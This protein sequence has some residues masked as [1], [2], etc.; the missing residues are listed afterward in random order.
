[1]IRA[2]PAPGIVLPGVRRVVLG[3]Q[4]LRHR[5]T[6]LDDGRRGT[7]ER[8][9]MRRCRKAGYGVH[10]LPPGIWR[11]LARV[12]V[13]QRQHRN[14]PLDELLGR[15]RAEGLVRPRRGLALILFSSVPERRLNEL[16]ERHSN[17]PVDPRKPGV[18]DL[19]VFKRRADKS[20]FALR[21]V[22]VKRPAEKVQPHQLAEIRF[23]RSIGLRAGVLRLI[24]AEPQP[25]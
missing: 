1:M 13:L 10:R 2:Q 25:R 16:I 22:E 3:R 19:L 12:R 11:S 15:L 8:I 18:P 5:V 24:E 7:S 21:F 4:R 20:P 6:Y 23:M 17:G 14:A 9:I